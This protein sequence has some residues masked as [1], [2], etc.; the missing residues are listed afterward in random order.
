MC[1]NNFKKVMGF[2]LVDYERQ[3]DGKEISDG[4][5]RSALIKM[6]YKWMSG[7]ATEIL[8]QVR[9]MSDEQKHHVVRGQKRY[10]A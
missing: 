6:A 9:V 8:Q 7:A 3:L 5:T 10:F 2:I 4:P 1:A